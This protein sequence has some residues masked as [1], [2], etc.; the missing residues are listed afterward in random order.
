MSTTFIYTLCEP[1]TG[2]VRYV[3]KTSN[4]KK[5]LLM[6]C[7]FARLKPRSNH[8]TCWIH[9]LLVRDLRP[10]LQI[11]DEVS[12]TEWP[13]WEVAWI[14]FY[15]EQGFNL[16]NS[17]AGGEGGSNPSED[18]RTKISASHV[19]RKYKPLSP[20]HRANISVGLRGKPKS[21]EHVEKVRLANIGKKR[22]SPSV[23]T[24][25]KRS[26][27][28][29]GKKRTPEQNAATSARQIGKPK[30]AEHMEKVR[31]SNLGRKHSAETREKHSR[32]MKAVWARR[33][34]VVNETGNPS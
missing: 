28:L 15:R 6:H 20:A 3:G 12:V 2:I 23:E 27:A 7:S 34:A 11:V 32:S 25:A 31:L 22:P 9:S 30:S 8:R 21:A 4:P 5:R 19:G 13:Q 14:E 24:L 16:V 18:T 17:N 26:A 10:I 33:K 29:R 1:E